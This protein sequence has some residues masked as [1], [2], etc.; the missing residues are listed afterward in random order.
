M[1]LITLPFLLHCIIVGQLPWFGVLQLYAVFFSTVL[2][3]HLTAHAHRIGGAQTEGGLVGLANCGSG[4]LRLSSGSWTGG[5]FLSVLP[6]HLTDLF[7]E[8]AACP[9][10]RRRIR[11]G[12]IRSQGRGF[13][14]GNSL[15]TSTLSPTVFTFLMQGLILLTLLVTAHR[16]WRNQALPRLFQ[17]FRSGAFRNLPISPPRMPLAFLFR[18]QR[19]QSFGRSVFQQEPEH[20]AVRR[21]PRIGHRTNRLSRTFDPRHSLLGQ[22]LLSQPPSLQQRYPTGRKTG[23]SPGSSLRRRKLGAWICD[24]SRPSDP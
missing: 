24:H 18:W 15:F 23:P 16:K 12:K 11:I 20:P 4:T 6:H 8:N 9:I 19:Q 7:R 5:D 22:R 21:H 3:Y 13:L 1:F 10:A 14:V 17:T 2:F